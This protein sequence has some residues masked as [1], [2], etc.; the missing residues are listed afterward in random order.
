[1]D[2]ILKL[3]AGKGDCKGMEMKVDGILLELRAGAD[4]GKDQ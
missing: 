2:F 4:R 3:A 1:M